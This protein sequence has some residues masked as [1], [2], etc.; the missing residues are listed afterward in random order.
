MRRSIMAVVTVAML[1]GAVHANDSAMNDGAYGPEPLGWR[2]GAESIVRMVDEKLLI[3]FH[4]DYSLVRVKFTFRNTGSTPARQLIG[5]P[6]QSAA[7]EI[8]M[9]LELEGQN[10]M[11][12]IEDL[13]TFVNGEET[14]AERKE[15]SMRWGENGT[16]QPVSDRG[17]DS[18]PMVWWTLW[19]D[20][21]VG[22][23]VTVE[24]RYRVKNGMTAGGP[25]WF[26]YTTA[27]GAAWRGTIGALTADVYLHSSLTTSDIMW[28]GEG[29]R[30]TSSAPPHSGWQAVSATH[31]RLVWRDFEPGTQEDRREFTVMTGTDYQASPA[32][33]LRYAARFGQEY[34]VR[35][36]LQ[37]GV[38]LNARDVNGLTAYHW[39]VI[40]D[41]YAVAR[42]LLEAG[43][44]P[45]IP[46]AQGRTPL[47]TAAKSGRAD[48][49]E[50]LLARG[51]NPAVR[52]RRGRTAADYADYNG[53]VTI[54][55]D[56]R[57]AAADRAPV[58]GGLLNLNTATMEELDALPRITPRVAQAIIDARNALPGARFRSWD[59]VDAVRG[60]GEATLAKLR[61]LAA[62]E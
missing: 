45:A 13:L 21:P 33:R 50:L 3:D 19:V 32:E 48:V 7:N 26:Q 9:K 59:Q 16:W 54:A 41:Q 36:L 2:P 1:A 8:A 24:R 28:W 37:E 5:F 20:F 22:K 15:G 51:V 39:T 29:G 46:D 18:Q 44:D 55:A 23:A 58:A 56:L 25:T 31:L 27:T 53:Y 52:D 40:R 47:M 11:G 57:A 38:D 60:V 6:D 43:A 34:V 62:L 42:D 10:V 14:W 35:M 61:E 30:L 4:P 17:E 49:V 12:P